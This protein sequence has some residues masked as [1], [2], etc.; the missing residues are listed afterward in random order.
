MAQNANLPTGT[1]TLNIT[2]SNGVV[3][4]VE[5]RNFND[6]SAVFQYLANQGKFRS[7]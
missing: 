2:T 4:Y 6:V 1:L 5:S 7:I 3:F